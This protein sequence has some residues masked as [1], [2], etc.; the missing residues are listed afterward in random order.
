MTWAKILVILHTYIHTICHTTSCKHNYNHIIGIETLQPYNW[1]RNMRISE[2]RYIKGLNLRFQLFPQRKTINIYCTIIL[3]TR[4]D[5]A[6]YSKDYSRKLLSSWLTIM[7][8]TSH[9]S[10][11]V[12]IKRHKHKKNKNKRLKSK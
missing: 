11:K 9:K 6:F 10:K 3:M 12:N 7:R 4:T 2:S 5:A 1:Y 8:W